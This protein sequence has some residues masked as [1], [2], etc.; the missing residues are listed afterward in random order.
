VLL[1][2]AF[3]PAIFALLVDHFGWR[4]SIYALMGCSI[5]TWVAIELMSRW[6]EGASKRSRSEG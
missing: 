6:Y 4:T 5:M 1:V 2:N 3:S